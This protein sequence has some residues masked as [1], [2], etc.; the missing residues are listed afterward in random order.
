MKNP[1]SYE[2]GVDISEAA[3]I[4]NVQGVQP[5]I[6]VPDI[7]FPDAISITKSEQY[8]KIYPNGQIRRMEHFIMTFSQSSMNYQEY[9]CDSQNITIRFFSFTLTS[10][11][12][13]FTPFDVASGLITPPVDFIYP[14]GTNNP[15][16]AQ[17]PEWNLESTDYSYVTWQLSPGFY[18]RPFGVVTFKLSRQSAGIL[19][20]L[21]MPILLIMLLCAFSWW[22]TMS[23]RVATTVTGLLAIAAIYIAVIG[24]I[25]LVGYLTRLD[26]YMFIMFVIIFV[27][28][29]FHMIVVRLN[30]AEIG[31]NWPLRKLLVRV[32]EFIGRVTMIP[33]VILTY[34]VCFWPSVR[35]GV[36]VSVC[37]LIGLFE[38]GMLVRYIPELK[39]TFYSTK[40]QIELKQGVKGKRAQ[41]LSAVEKRF[42]S[43]FREG[44]RG[45]TGADEKDADDGTRSSVMGVE[46]QDTSVNPLNNKP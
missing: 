34:I 36:V 24:A 15:S 30:V 20:R 1:A 21:C 32:I 12:L 29:I 4:S 46:L 45:E 37:V 35:I 38:Y 44:T 9:P 33:W 8:L 27:N 2:V 40:V 22:G 25:P 10:D 18:P 42:L 31:L 7:V 28:T 17:N 5:L 23:E 16:F 43:L 39:H 14:Q 13:I 41:G 3:T 26:E 19:Q 6:W 11:Q